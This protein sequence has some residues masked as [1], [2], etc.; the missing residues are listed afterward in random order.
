MPSS[1]GRDPTRPP[2]PRALAADKTPL[3]GA[4]TLLRAASPRAAPTPEAAPPSSRPSRGWSPP[5][6]PASVAPPPGRAQPPTPQAARRARRRR[7]PRRRRPPAPRAP[8]CAPPSTRTR[9]R[10]PWTGHEPSRAAGRAGPR[11]CLL[12]TRPRRQEGPPLRQCPPRRGPA[13]RHSSPPRL[14]PPARCGLARGPAPAA[15]GRTRCW[16]IAWHRTTQRGSDLREGARRSQWPRGRGAPPCR[17]PPFRRA[18][19]RRSTR[20][21]LRPP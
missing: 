9:G 5:P 4:E 19:G 8:R 15:P 6:R 21:T 20:A 18:A 12:R 11:R 14:G 7:A 2:Q 16:S 17:S 3:P 1:E 10:P 13:I